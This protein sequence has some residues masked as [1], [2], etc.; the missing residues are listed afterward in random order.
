[1]L[2]LLC[3]NSH[4]VSLLVHSACT[5][6]GTFTADRRTALL[7]AQCTVLLLGTILCTVFCQFLYKIL[8]YVYTVLIW[9]RSIPNKNANKFSLD[10]RGAQM[11]FILTRKEKKK[12]HKRTSPI[13]FCEILLMNW[14]KA[15]PMNNGS[16]STKRFRLSQDYVQNLFLLHSSPWSFHLVD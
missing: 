3:L 5:F 10:M 9:N 14:I 6:T 16:I 13:T 2:C 12:G 11:H 8:F 7:S 1:M 15:G 4:L